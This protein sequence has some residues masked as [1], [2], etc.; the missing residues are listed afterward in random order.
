V[1]LKNCGSL[2]FIARENTPTLQTKGR[3]LLH[4]EY[5]VRL[6]LHYQYMGDNSYIMNIRG[7]YSYITNIREVTPTLP[8][9][10]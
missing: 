7:D 3:L 6:L 5:K 10:G 8:I 1:Y 2:F 9:Q 4:Y